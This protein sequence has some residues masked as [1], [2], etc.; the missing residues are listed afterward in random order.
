FSVMISTA[1]SILDLE[2]YKLRLNTLR[3][4]YQK[5]S[6]YPHIVINDFLNPD[7]LRKCVV[8]FDQLNNSDGWINYKHFNEKKRGLNKAELLPPHIKATIDQLSTPEFLEFLSDL[9]GIKNLQRDDHLEGGGIHQSTRGGFLNIHAD[10]TVH[11]H[12]R[13]WQRRIN[14]LVYLNEGWKEEWGGKLELWDREMKGCVESVLPVFNRCVIFNTDPDSYH[15]HPDPMTCPEDSYRRSIA[16]YYYTIEE[17]PLMRSTHYV[18]RP[19]E[20]RK[21]WRIK[22]DN[23]MIA[24]YTKMKGVL[25]SND[26]V[27]SK[28]L[29]WFQK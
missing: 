20:K 18:A 19:E 15:G 17:N 21:E 6:P 16:L 7:E 10:F 29:N 3:E 26:S 24:V 14:I 12:H 5:A 22:L 27:V 4:Q 11:P 13:H 2:S 8:E 25:G 9:T 1:S 28:I 23:F